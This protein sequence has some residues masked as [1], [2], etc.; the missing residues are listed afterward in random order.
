MCAAVAW[1]EARERLAQAGWYQSSYIMLPNQ[2]P[3]IRSP[4]IES[5]P[6]ETMLNVF[7]Y[8]HTEEKLL[9]E[10]DGKVSARSAFFPF[11][12]ATVCHRWRD[13]LGLKAV[14]WDC[15]AIMLE[16]CPDASVLRVC[17]DAFKQLKT[18]KLYLVYGDRVDI[19]VST[20]N[21]RCSSL[22]RLLAPHLSKCEVISV[23]VRYRS[24]IVAATRILD[25]LDARNLVELSLESEVTDSTN[26]A[27][28][29]NFISPK[30]RTL[31]MDAKTFLA[32]SKAG[33]RKETGVRIKYVRYLHVTSYHPKDKSPHLER[34]QLISA[35][36]RFTKTYGLVCQLY[37]R[38]VIFNPHET[39][40]PG[41]IEMVD[42]VSFAAVDGRFLRE[43]LSHFIPASYSQGRESTLSLARCHIVSPVFIRFIADIYLTEIDDSATIL[44]LLKHWS[45]LS[46]QI[47]DCPGFTDNVLDVMAREY[48]CGGASMFIFK[49]CSISVSGAR[50]FVSSMRPGGNFEELHVMGAP[51]MTDEDK[52]WFRDRVPDDLTWNGEVL[53]GEGLMDEFLDDN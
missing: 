25:S 34:S 13:I 49:N 37:V 43:F 46:V 45:G 31:S 11:G 4:F 5:L 22:I 32:F 29:T 3:S 52:Y 33:K 36:V 16:L 1:R 30:L 42:D 6:T 15:V 51:D 17:L 9:P 10:R 24:T 2:A 7:D 47:Y 38:D 20:E 26:E 41:V 39:R 19:S 21:A 35:I 53:K 8:L 12:V 23:D 44:H 48:L 18:I 40:Q 27:L 50:R 14:Y 28:F